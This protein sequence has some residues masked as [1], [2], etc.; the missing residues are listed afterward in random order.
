[1]SIPVAVLGAAGRGAHLAACCRATGLLHVQAVC[2]IDATRAETARQACGA[3]E[4]YTDLDDLLAHAE[5]EA[6]LIGTPMH[7]HADQA[8]AA[9]DAGKHVLCEVVPAVTWDQARRL[10]SA[11]RRSRGVFVLGENYDFWRPNLLVAELARQGRFGT[12]YAAEGEYLHQVRDLNP[13]G[14]WR[15]RWQTGIDGNT[16]ITHALGPIQACLGDDRVAAVSH[17]GGGRRHRDHAGL[18]FELQ[19]HG[20]TTARTAGG[21]VL[22]LRLDLLSDRPHATSYRILGTD[23]CYESRR[24]DG[25]ADRIWLRSCHGDEPRWHDLRELEA[26]HADDVWR[27]WGHLGEQHPDL[28]WHGG[29]DLLEIATFAEVISGRRPNPLAIDAAMDLTLPGLA[30]QDSAAADGAWITVPDS[31]SWA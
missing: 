19:S 30:S 12:I 27:A 17:V 21:A 1:M 28:G 11:A 31:R 7:L 13:V 8:V 14:G 5:I 16:Y 25:E 24:H 15:R 26:D 3:V 20:V 6:V 23:G 4:A 29:A 2:E 9:L 22:T 18:P 10:V